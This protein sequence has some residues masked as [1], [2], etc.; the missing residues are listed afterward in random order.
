MADFLS[1]NL[2][3]EGIASSV[4][5]QVKTELVFINC[6][7]YRHCVRFLFTIYLGQSNF[8][9]NFFSYYFAEVFFFPFL[10]FSK[11]TKIV[12]TRRILV[13]YRRIICETKNEIICQMIER[14]I[15]TDG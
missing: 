12:R 9:R 13:T 6:N 14:S 2:L 8:F 5:F 3:L 10:R 1:I 4:D 11:T 15:Q 7:M